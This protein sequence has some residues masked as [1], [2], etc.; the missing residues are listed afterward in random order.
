MLSFLQENRSY[1]ED[2]KILSHKL[3]KARK[4]VSFT[5]LCTYFGFI[6][7]INAQEKSS[8]IC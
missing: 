1:S 8:L 4:I 5:S 6:L 3:G 7:S 2:M